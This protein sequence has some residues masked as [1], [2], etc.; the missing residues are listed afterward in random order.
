VVKDTQPKLTNGYVRRG[1]DAGALLHGQVNS[2]KSEETGG[3]V[4]S[5]GGGGVA[6]IRVGARGGGG[7][8]IHTFIII[9]L[10]LSLSLTHTQNLRPPHVSR[11]SGRSCLIIHRPHLH[12]QPWLRKHPLRSR[13]FRHKAATPR[14]PPAR[15]NE[16]WRPRPLILN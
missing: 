12:L 13:L 6:F 5:G 2:S 10:S 7:R 3:G 11:A 4:R 15:M 1:E 16:R 14:W 9:S 8:S